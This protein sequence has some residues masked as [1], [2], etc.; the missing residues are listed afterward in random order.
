MFLIKLPSFIIEFNRS[1]PRF[2]FTLIKYLA[3]ILYLFFKLTYFYKM[4]F[5]TMK[6][7]REVSVF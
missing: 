6:T 3:K 5:V 1:S 2:F 4:F 7:G